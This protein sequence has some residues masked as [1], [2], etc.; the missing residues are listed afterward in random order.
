MQKMSLSWSMTQSRS[1]IL[2]ACT[3]IDILPGVP[4]LDID[5]GACKTFGDCACSFLFT[6]SLCVVTAIDMGGPHCGTSLQCS[7]GSLTPLSTYQIGEVFF[8]VSS[9]KAQAC[10]EEAKSTTEEEL[11]NLKKE[12]GEAEAMMSELR[13]Q[14]YAK[15]GDN[16]NLEDDS[17]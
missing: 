15:F 16:I 7:V 13:V 5:R 1:H 8:H 14:L 4:G 6:Q 10:I 9:E 17:S 3:P 12:V 2:P 11:S